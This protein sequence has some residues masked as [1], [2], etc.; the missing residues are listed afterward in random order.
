MA[1][2]ALRAAGL[3][4]EVN[5]VDR[6]ATREELYLGLPRADAFLACLTDRVDAALLESA[7]RLK[8]V[9]NFAVGYN[10]IDLPAARERRIF[11]TNTPGV[12]TAATADL[13]LALLLALARRLAEGEALVRG[14]RWKGWGPLQL[15]GLDLEGRILGIVGAGAIGSAVARRAAA[16][17]M[18]IIYH[19]RSRSSR[20]EGNVPGAVRVPFE[21]LLREADVVSVHLPYSAAVH[22]LFGERTF[23][24]MK[25]DALFLNT[26]RGPVH[27]EGALVRALKEGWIAGAGLDVYEKEPSVHPELL[28]MPNTVLLPHLGSATRR[29][30]DR[31]AMLAATNILAVMRGERPPNLVPEL[32]ALA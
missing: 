11:V 22:H 31:M 2:E 29:T 15:L 28:T 10:N 12:L 4:V 6:A 23:R 20:L 19:S 16:F 30:R 9:A 25:R 8:V 24:A 18:R 32:S 27:D 26:A 1:V 14:G 3:V 21:H 13:T 5:P 17:G 7:P